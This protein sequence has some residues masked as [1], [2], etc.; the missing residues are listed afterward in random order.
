MGSRS[1]GDRHDVSGVLDHLGLRL[2]VGGRGSGVF[3]C[4]RRRGVQSI[5]RQVDPADDQGRRQYGE[6]QRPR[7]R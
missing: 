5:D 1:P 3:H 2:S 7:C 6:S 4:V